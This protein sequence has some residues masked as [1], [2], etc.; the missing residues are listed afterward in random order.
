M[1]E[2]PEVETIV[3]G[4][5]RNILKFPIAQVKIKYPKIFIAPKGSLAKYLVNDKFIKIERHGKYMKL[6]TKKGSRIVVHLR[7]TGQLFLAN[8]G[9]QP[10]KHVHLMLTFKHGEKL[11]YRDIRKFGRWVVVPPHKEFKDFI[12]AGRDALSIT[13]DELAERILKHS[14][15]KLKAFLLNQTIIAGI[16]NIYAD[17]IC[18]ALKKHPE[19]QINKVDLDQL[20]AS[21]NKILNLAIKYNGTTISDYRTSKSKKGSFQNLLKIYQR[22]K[23]PRCKSLVLRKKVAGRSSYF[24]V[25][26]QKKTAG[27]I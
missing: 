7:M 4:L 11:I 22:D 19:T 8:N 24:C 23:C 17:E 27:I 15:M 10:D 9:Y 12:N 1:P 14:S 18:F 21:I 25:K 5:R 13:K 2:L 20:H 16:G 3:R 26:C 6:T